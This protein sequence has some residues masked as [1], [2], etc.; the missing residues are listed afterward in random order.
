[1]TRQ[2]IEEDFSSCDAR[3]LSRFFRDY[4]A[5][6]GQSDTN[7]KQRN[8]RHPFTWL[9]AEYDHRHPYTPQLNRYAPV[10]VDTVSPV[11]T[12]L[13]RV[14]GNGKARTSATTP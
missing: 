6:H 1:M 9:E 10:T 2:G 12:D 5:E 8:L 4:Q 13:L 14:T 3:T 7:T 11:V